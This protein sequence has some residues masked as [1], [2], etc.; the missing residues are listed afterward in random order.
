MLET[1]R[2][3]EDN[4]SIHNTLN[5]RQRY[6]IAVADVCHFMRQN[7]FDFI[8]GHVVEQAGADSDERACFW[9]RRLQR[10]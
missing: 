5:Q 4:K 2:A 6:H 3:K 10:R 7:G 8:A 9:L 1:I